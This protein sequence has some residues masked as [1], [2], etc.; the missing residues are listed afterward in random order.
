MLMQFILI[1]VL[2]AVAWFL[3]PFAVRKLSEKRLAELCRDNK[4]IVLSYDDGPGADLT[5]RL[6]D[7]LKQHQAVATFFMLGRATQANP[8]TVARA[9][10][11]GH[12]VGSHSF[13]HANAWKVLP[14]RA[15]RDLAAGI[16]AVRTLGGDGHLFRPPYGKLTLATL[17][18]GLLRRQSFGWWTIDTRDTKDH[19][20]R[21][22]VQDILDQIRTGGGGVV[23]AHDFDRADEPPDGVSHTD[24][25]MTL[26]EQVIAFADQNGYRLMR[27]GDVL[28]RAQA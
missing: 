28:R 11:E 5:P 19:G 27:L 13:D 6:L 20:A 16:H 12:E 21:R 8:E 17:L 22:P 9:L 14:V 18:D 2:G 3:L 26:T 24:Y 1:V 4:A 25:V 10:R 7:L 23:L 15:A